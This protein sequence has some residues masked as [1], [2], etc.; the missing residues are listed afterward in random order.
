MHPDKGQ[1]ATHAIWDLVFS[2]STFPDLQEV[3]FNATHGSEIALPSTVLANLEVDTS[4]GFHDPQHLFSKRTNEPYYGLLKM[5]R[6]ILAHNP[7]LNP[8]VLGSLFNSNIIPKRLSTLEIVNCPQLR[9]IGDLPVIAALLERGLQRLQCL[10]LHITRSDYDS[11]HAFVHNA[12]I[13]ENPEHHICN[14]VREFGQ[15][16]ES[17][18]LALPFACNRMLIPR[19]H[20]ATKVRT[21]PLELPPIPQE[22]IE[23]LPQRLFAQGY[24]YRSLRVYF[25]ICRGAHDWDEMVGLAADQRGDVSWELV[26]EHDRRSAWCVGGHARVESEWEEEVDLDESDTDSDA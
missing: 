14:V 4:Q 21:Q 22:P 1:S 19:L 16:I 15:K 20:K 8:L 26:S 12:E 10:K 9:V 3:Y 7:L 2:G 5:E 11:Y 23:T 18:D 6:I 17:L 13:D 24:H 25:G